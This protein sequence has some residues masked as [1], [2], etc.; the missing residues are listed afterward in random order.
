M[1]L[2]GKLPTIPGLSFI[3]LHHGDTGD[4]LGLLN[5]TPWLTDYAETAALIATLDLVVTV[6]TSIAHL[7]GALGKPVWILLPHA[8]D[9]RWLLD[10]S[11]S[12]WYRSARLFRQPAPGDWTSVLTQV[13]HG[14]ESLSA[15]Q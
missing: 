10:R 3:N 4:D 6:D 7:A 9:W 14:L 8:P 1:D 5:L 15:Q 11:D 12:P 13:M 2:V